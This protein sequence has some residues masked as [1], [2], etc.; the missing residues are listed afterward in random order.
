MLDPPRAAVSA[1][2]AKCQQ[3]GIKVIVITGDNPTTAESICRRIG[4][5][6]SDEDLTG[7]SYTGSEFEHMTESQ[8]V[9]AITT[10]SLFSRVEPKH[11]LELV[12]LL[13]QQGHV[14]AMTGDGVNDSR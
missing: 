1:S 3:A 4:V 8:K 6:D 5:F 13:K 10:A 9:K 14:V 2:I 12:I 11:K 7:K